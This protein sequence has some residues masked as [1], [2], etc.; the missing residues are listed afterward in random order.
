[1]TT[2]NLDTLLEKVRS[3]EAKGDLAGAV[4]T[5][6][7]APDPLKD[8]GV[9]NYARGSLAFRQGDLD[10]AQRHFEKAIEAEPEIAEYRS[11]LGAVLLERAKN[12]DAAAGAKAL[13]VMKGA[14]R[15][16]AAL[17]ETYVNYGLAL[18]VAKR[19]EEALR[20]FD[21]AL[22]MDK[23]HQNARYNRAAALNALEQYDDA[24]AALD[25][26]LKDAPNHP[27]ALASRKRLAERTKK[28]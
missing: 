20:A 15:W 23:T 27:Q 26:L 19:N 6:Q 10:T 14:M 8:R 11:N 7:G 5:L 9:W 17:P 21:Q 3:L 25:A 22:A 12:G 28:A 4:T 24:L 2:A 13:E 1:M 18:L 16:G